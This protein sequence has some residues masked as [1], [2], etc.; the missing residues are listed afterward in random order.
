[1][2]LA[3]DE[4]FSG[5]NWVHELCQK[6]K[7]KDKN[8]VLNTL[9]I[10]INWF[11]TQNIDHKWMLL[12]KDMEGNSFLLKLCSDKI[13]KKSLLAMMGWLKASYPDIFINIIMS[14][15]LA[16][17]NLLHEICLLSDGKEKN[18]DK[19]YGIIIWLNENLREIDFYTFMNEKNIYGDIFLNVLLANNNVDAKT[20][21]SNSLKLILD[22]EALDPNL[23][24]QILQI[25][26]SFGLDFMSILYQNADILVNQSNV[27]YSL[28]SRLN[29]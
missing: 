4:N 27:I 3:F 8:L 9:Q 23:L 22:L 13:K 7:K 12:H 10:L 17:N 20:I 11:T 26:N 2:Q 18:T 1:M 29:L 15:N 28:G 21:L 14:K 25:R 24:R 6:A 5:N 19:I 16:G